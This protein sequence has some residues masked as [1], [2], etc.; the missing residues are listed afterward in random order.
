LVYDLPIFAIG[1]LFGAGLLFIGLGLGF[2]LG[3]KTGGPSSRASVWDQKWTQLLENWS[4]RTDGVANVVSGCRSALGRLDDRCRQSQHPDGSQLPDPASE[5]LAQMIETSEHVRQ[6][7]ERAEETLQKQARDISSYMSEARTDTLTGLPNR[8]ALD[9]ELTR[10]LNECNRGATLSLIIFDIDH[11]KRFNDRYGHLAGDAV[12]VGVGR[13]LRQLIS[14]PALAARLGGEEFA[15]VL[16]GRQAA[17]AGRLAEQ[18]RAALER[19][20]CSY[21]RKQLHVT[22]SCGVT[23]ARAGE[24]MLDLIKRADQALYASKSAGRNCSHLHDGSQCLPL[25]RRASGELVM[26][27][28]PDGS[29]RQKLLNS[30]DF[31]QLCQDM[32]SRLLSLVENENP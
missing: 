19:T 23:E 14:E 25:T 21:E 9:S 16:P 18:V 5:L 12:L 26:A 32:R 31:Q 1:L 28:N 27:V 8:R 20:P 17:E 22:I 3:R 10:R 6:R 30:R 2:W 15:V 13:V 29:S 7:L 24:T 4:Q 11:F